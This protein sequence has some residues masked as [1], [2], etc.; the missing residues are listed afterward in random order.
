VRVTAVLFC[1]FVSFRHSAGGYLL[2]ALDHS[3][4][5]QHGWQQFAGAQLLQFGNHTVLC[6]IG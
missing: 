4:R 6:A 2:L 3:K 1:V 5:V